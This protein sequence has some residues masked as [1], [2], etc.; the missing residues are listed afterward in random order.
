MPT[1]YDGLTALTE[2]LSAGEGEIA[3][4]LLDAGADPNAPDLSKRAP[5]LVATHAAILNPQF[6]K[7]LDCVRPLAAWPGV[8]QD[9][10]HQGKTALQM[11]KGAG[12]EDLVRIFEARG[13]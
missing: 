9:A 2:L 13:Q 8:R 11:A 3:K 1:S 6:T 12:R 10:T 4:E 5:L 7:F